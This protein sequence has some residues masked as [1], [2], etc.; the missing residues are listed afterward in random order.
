L[1]HGALLI[2]R[3]TF[4]QTDVNQF[5]M[6]GSEMQRDSPSSTSKCEVLTEGM[7][8]SM[9]TCAIVIGLLT[10]LSCADATISTVRDPRVPG[11]LERI[12]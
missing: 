1:H 9:K 2:H 4:L 7:D 8:I 12:L 3:L 5:F 6:I 10:V 11:R